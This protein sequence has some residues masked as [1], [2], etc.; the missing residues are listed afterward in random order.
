VNDVETDN[1]TFAGNASKEV[2]VKLT[3]EGAEPIEYT[4][5]Y[6]YVEPVVAPVT[7][8]TLTF[9]KTDAAG[10]VIETLEN[11][12][13][14]AALNSAAKD[15]IVK[16]PDVPEGQEPEVIKEEVFL[17]NSKGTT[18]DLN[19]NIVE[20]L[21]LFNISGANIIDTSEGNTG[22]LKVPENIVVLPDENQ[23]TDGKFYLP[24]YDS[25]NGG[26]RFL[27]VYD[28]NTERLWTLIENKPGGRA[29]ADFASESLETI[30]YLTK[31]QFKYE[32]VKTL[33]E[34]T[35]TGV[36]MTVKV[37]YQ[38]MTMNDYDDRISAETDVTNTFRT[39]Y[40]TS[41]AKSPTLMVRI[42]GLANMVAI[43]ADTVF[44]YGVNAKITLSNMVDDGNGGTKPEEAANIRG[45]RDKRDAKQNPPAT[46]DDG[47]NGGDNGGN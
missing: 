34:N 29:A 40:L 2:S 14:Q 28:S 12:T 21:G 10:N 3:K 41:T 16:L 23:G 25:A 38:G 24:V 19:G 39:K 11:T 45:N 5:S 22:L 31:P 20:A 43:K 33:F 18:I 32:N 13:L 36:T 44:T 46:G 42:N 27:Y 35:N 1:I 26:Y 6:S 47:Q 8:P 7:E 4:Y 17:V 30:A 9:T 37:Y 15:E